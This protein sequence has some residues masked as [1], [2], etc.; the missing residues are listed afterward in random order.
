MSASQKER[1]LSQSTMARRR[2]LGLSSSA[3]MY[4]CTS[5]LRMIV[6][7]GLHARFGS[8]QHFWWPTPCFA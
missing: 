3:F 6:P 8:R 5:L 1:T 2:V 7:S 4:S